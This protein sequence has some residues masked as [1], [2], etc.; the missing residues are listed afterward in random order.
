MASEGLD[1]PSLNTEFL[2]T[3]K[4]DIVQIVGRILR[5]KHAYSHPIIYDFVDTHEVF[6]RQWC[7]RKAYYKKQQYKIVGTDSVV[8]PP[9]RWR[10]MFEPLN[11]NS[12]K[13]E[14]ELLEEEDLD[15]EEE[16]ADDL[17]NGDS[18]VQNTAKSK[19]TSMFGGKCLLKIKR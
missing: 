4:T 11:N 7:K 17:D 12:S 9:T 6:Q 8:Y 18:R 15:L 13:K 16:D 3:P 19:T 14:D 2:I 1:I 10:P 5:A